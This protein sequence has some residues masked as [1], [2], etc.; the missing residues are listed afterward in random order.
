[1]IE[2]AHGMNRGAE[3]QIVEQKSVEAEKV[4]GRSALAKEEHSTAGPSSVR[5]PRPVG[6]R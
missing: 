5:P 1:V 4:R 3:Q 2:G 6:G